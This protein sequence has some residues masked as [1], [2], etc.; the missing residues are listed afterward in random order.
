MIQDLNGFTEMDEG[1]MPEVWDLGG[2]GVKNSGS[3]TKPATF[4]GLEEK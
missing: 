4:L 2:G 3:T 1:F